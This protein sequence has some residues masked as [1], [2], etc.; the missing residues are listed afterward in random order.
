MRSFQEL[1]N[2][3]VSAGDRSMSLQKNAIP[4]KLGKAENNPKVAAYIKKG[5]RVD[6]N[7]Q[8]AADGEQFIVKLTH[9]SGKQI[10]VRI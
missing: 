8:M 5:Y 1:L 9:Q 2:E 3:V 10:E 7:P 6:G 4:G